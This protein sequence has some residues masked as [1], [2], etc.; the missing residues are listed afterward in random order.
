M[1][2][3]P[4]RLVDFLSMGEIDSWAMD[5]CT[6]ILGSRLRIA[7]YVQ[8]HGLSVGSCI[9]DRIQLRNN[10]FRLLRVVLSIY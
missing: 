7:R 10:I 2:T 8:K 1:T 9:S 5:T 4:R 6:Y 3:L